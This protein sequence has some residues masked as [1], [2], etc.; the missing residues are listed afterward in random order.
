NANTGNDF[1]RGQRSETLS[2][3]EQH[4][5]EARPADHIPTPT[6]PTTLAPRG[7]SHRPGVIIHLDR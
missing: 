5:V 1:R 4:N 7:L 2:P 3:G 6:S